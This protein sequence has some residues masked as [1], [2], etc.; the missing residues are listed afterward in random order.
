M[1]QLSALTSKLTITITKPTNY[2]ISFNRIDKNTWTKEDG[3]AVKQ[4][5]KLAKGPMAG[6]G[7][8]PTNK[9]YSIFG[10]K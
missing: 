1:S 8:D 4:F 6:K 3:M 2:L 10:S 9:W 5:T 7:P